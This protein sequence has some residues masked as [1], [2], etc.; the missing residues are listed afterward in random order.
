MKSFHRVQK[1]T[2]TTDALM[3]T[4]I[5]MIRSKKLYAKGPFSGVDRGEMT[6]AQGGKE[7]QAKR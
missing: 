1:K 5:S 7:Q 2:M 3:M 6:S 4:T